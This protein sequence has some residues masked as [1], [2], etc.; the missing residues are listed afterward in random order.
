MINML[1]VKTRGLPFKK[2][3]KLSSS[4]GAT[5][6]LDL[7]ELELTKEEKGALDKLLARGDLSKLNAK[8]RDVLADK[9]ALISIDD[10]QSL[11][12]RF[13]CKWVKIS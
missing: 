10:S 7:K 9:K 5:L 4:T 6:T 11:I 3:L 8:E 2:Q 13:D 12:V 1:E